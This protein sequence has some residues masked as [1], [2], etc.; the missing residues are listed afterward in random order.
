MNDRHPT[1]SVP[2]GHPHP[3]GEDLISDLQA[4]QRVAVM[5][6]LVKHGVMVA[7]AEG[8]NGAEAIA[9]TRQL[10]AP[11]VQRL[12]RAAEDM[13]LV[14]S[15]G[16]HAY[17]VTVRGERLA[18]DHPRSL[19]SSIMLSVDQY[20]PAWRAL[21]EGVRTGLPTFADVHGY[22]PWEWRRKNP[23]QGEHFNQW[24]AEQSR[25]VLGDI[26]NA[27]ELESAQTVVDI[28]GGQGTL[29]RACHARWPHLQLVLFEQAQTLAA[30]PQSSAAEPPITKVA[31]D[32]FQSVPVRG[33]VFLLKSILHDWE[34]EAAVAILRQCAQAMDEHTRLIVIERVLQQGL[35]PQAHMVDLAMLL[36]TGGRER[37]AAEFNT[38]LKA[39][40]LQMVRL[41]PTAGDFS[42]MS[43]QRIV[44]P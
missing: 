42:L 44:Q 8:I 38:L 16:G 32:F 30:L 17:R 3:A 41:T 15:D 1:D 27:L 13:G 12:L 37:S 6:A 28:G 23:E 34:D 14:A 33:D 24:Q 31:G 22:P 20:W 35:S 10:H 40:D 21:H 5:H 25:Q 29:L 36:V 19:H 26:L 2:T 7:I 11:S 9:Q 39:A 4:Y 43:C 18:P